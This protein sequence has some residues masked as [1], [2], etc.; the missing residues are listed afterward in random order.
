MPNE[1]ELK[2]VEKLLALMARYEA[3]D[4]HLKAGSPPIYRVARLVRRL[5]TP[6]LSA[7][8]VA[9]L[10]SELLTPKFR[11]DLERTGNT[12]FAYSIPGVGRFRLNVYKQR[13]SISLAA[14]RVFTEIPSL[15]ELNLPESL[16]QVC[17][18][19]QGLVIVA[20]ITGSGKTTTLASLIDRINRTRRCHILTI[21]DPI[22]YLF[23]DDLAFVNQREVGLDV[24][25]YPTALKYMVREDPDVI[26]I[27]ELRDAPSFEAA[28]I[29][30]ETGHLV[31]GAMHASSAAQSVGRMLDLFPPDKHQQIRSLLQFNLRAMFVQKLLRG[32]KPEAPVVPAVEIMY[33]N[34][35]IR[36]MIREREDSKIPDIIQSSR[37][38]GMQTLNQSLEQLVR[39]GLI[40]EKVALEASANPEALRMILS[41]ISFQADRATI[42]T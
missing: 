28:L 30:S 3:T 35:T 18:Y 38:L 31:F 27:G 39:S 21:E 1:K 19:D 15:K 29:A 34:P 6:P 17:S 4:L 23:K 24:D 12:D 7:E 10:V 33:L 22:E 41:G 8:R 5:E 36:K 25:S 11:A 16:Y 37:E 40:T 42:I 14:R 20:G 13:G 9:L 2:E 32:A 26:L